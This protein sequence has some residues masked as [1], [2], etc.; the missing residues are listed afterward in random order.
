MKLQYLVIFIVLLLGGCS[1]KITYQTRPI[2]QL[3]EADLFSS[4]TIN[5]GDTLEA[6]YI[7]G[8]EPV[9]EYRLHVADLVSVRFPSQPYLDI[10]QRIRP[11]GKITL[12]HISDIL[13]E[14]LTPSDAVSK[15]NAIYSKTMRSQEMDLYV[16][17][18]GSDIEELRQV[19]TTDSSGQSKKLLVRPDGRIGFP[20]IGEVFAV[21]KT[22]PEIEKEINDKYKVKWPD[23][24][25]DILLVETAGAKLYVLGEVERDGEYI[26]NSPM[27]IP[28]VL[29]IAGGRTDLADNNYVYIARMNNNEYSLKAYEMTYG[30]ITKD[31]SIPILSANDILY[32]PRSGIGNASVIMEQLSKSI[33]FNGWGFSFTREIDK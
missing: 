25:V 21:G 8:S 12:P 22:I 17:E 18:S 32:I 10:E 11:D 15:I 13:V 24:L 1:Q 26:I 28:Q 19:I 31:G 4:Y 29:A 3:P 20:A 23:I 27:T 5:S 7:F 14:G 2:A 33:L 6:V 30:L 9:D 16:L